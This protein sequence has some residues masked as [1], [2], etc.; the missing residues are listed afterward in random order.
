MDLERAFRDGFS[1]SV[2][3]DEFV[4]PYLFAQT[5]YATHQTWPWGELR[6]EYKGLLQWLGRQNDYDD[7]DVASTYRALMTQ[8]DV[9]DIKKLLQKRCR[10]HKAC[11]CGSDRKA[12]DCCPDIKA[13]ISRIR[14]SLNR[15]LLPPLS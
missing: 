4:V 9:E 14:I 1:M 8:E 3:I 2:Y 7:Q 6:H 13:A 5:Y 11:P 12:R 15:G 10:G